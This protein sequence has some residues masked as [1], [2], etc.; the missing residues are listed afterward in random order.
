MSC[1]PPISPAPGFQTQ[2][3]E[4]RAK[5]FYGRVPQS[6]L[7]PDLPLITVVGIGPGANVKE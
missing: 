4:H 1:F 6:E 5:N 3:E 7:T 2:K